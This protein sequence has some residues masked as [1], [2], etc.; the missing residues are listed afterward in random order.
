MQYD[1]NYDRFDAQL[2]DSLNVIHETIRQQIEQLFRPI[3]H[4]HNNYDYPEPCC[5]GQYHNYFHHGFFELHVTPLEYLEKMTDYSE[6][7]KFL[8]FI[9]SFFHAEC[10]TNIIVRIGFGSGPLIRKN[11]HIGG[12]FSTTKSE[13][14]LILWQIYYATKSLRKILLRGGELAKSPPRS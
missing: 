12:G 2:N 13:S 5:Y 14:S 3:F 1:A 11:H 8:N 6:E 10:Q 9:Y 4:R 7:N